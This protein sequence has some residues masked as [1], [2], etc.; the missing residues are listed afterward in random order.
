MENVILL[1]LLHYLDECKEKGASY[2]PLLKA[3]ALTLKDQ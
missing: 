2:I 1:N 3:N